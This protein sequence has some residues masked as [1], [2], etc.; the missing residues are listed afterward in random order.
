LRVR[1]RTGTEFDFVFGHHS[2]LIVECSCED[3]LCSTSTG[4]EA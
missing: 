2:W 4:Q 3:H 1:S